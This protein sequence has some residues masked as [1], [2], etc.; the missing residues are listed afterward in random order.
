MFWQKNSKF[1][2]LS[3]NVIHMNANAK[4]KTP[5]KSEPSTAR[6]DLLK[7]KSNKELHTPRQI[8]LNNRKVQNGIHKICYVLLTDGQNEMRFSLL[9]FLVNREHFWQKLIFW[10]FWGDKTHIFF[11]KITDF[12][13]SIK[14]LFYSFNSQH[15]RSEMHF[16]NKVNRKT[17]LALKEKAWTLEYGFWNTSF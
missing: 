2:F 16:P 10:Y 6:Y 7:M 13:N 11:I 4:L 8:A 14:T 12:W 1:R 9:C 5:S 17:R 15:Y 3:E